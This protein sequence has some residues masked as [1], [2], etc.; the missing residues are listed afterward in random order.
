LMRH[1]IRCTASRAWITNTVTMKLAILAY[2]R[3]SLAAAFTCT[4][5]KTA[6]SAHLRSYALE[7]HCPITLTLCIHTPEILSCNDSHIV[8]PMSIP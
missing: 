7:S 5:S 6:V 1:S 8:P 2:P 4:P 3:R